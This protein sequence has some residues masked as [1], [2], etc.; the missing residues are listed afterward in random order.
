MEMPKKLICL[1]FLIFFVVLGSSFLVAEEEP[2]GEM[3]VPMGAIELK[4]PETVEAKRSPVSF[5]HTKHFGYSCYECHHKWEGESAI[6]NCTTSGCHDLDASPKQSP[7]K[8]VDGN[9]AARYY[10]K[11]FHAKCI[12]CHKEIRLKNIE[13]EYKVGLKDPKIV[14]P[15][16]TGCIECHPK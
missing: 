16:P 14:N 11:A 2:E 6:K 12:G 1:F 9:Y 5:P 4:S 7:G 8:K 3:C 15:G 10:K 13:K